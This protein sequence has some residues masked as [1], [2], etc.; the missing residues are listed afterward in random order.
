M[1]VMSVYLVGY[2]P[3]MVVGV[4]H[5]YISILRN[6]LLAKIGA[7]GFYVTYVKQ[8]KKMRGVKGHPDGTKFLSIN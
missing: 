2:C 8:I 6:T 3:T 5:N 1:G 4:L 7:I